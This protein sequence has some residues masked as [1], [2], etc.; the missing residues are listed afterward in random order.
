MKI[1]QMFTLAIGLAAMG[2]GAA[3]AGEIFDPP[4]LPTG[5]IQ[6]GPDEDATYDHNT[7]GPA[8]EPGFAFHGFSGILTYSSGY[9]PLPPA[10]L[11]VQAAFIQTYPGNGAQAGGAIDWTVSG[12]TVGKTYKLTFYDIALNTV[13]S[14]PFTVSALGGAPSL[15]TPASSWIL[16]SYTF[17][18]LAGV[19]DIDFLGTVGAPG[20]NQASALT[21]LSLSAVPEPSTLGLLLMGLFGIGF[22]ARGARG[23]DRAAAI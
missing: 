21:D 23:K 11:G 3:N 12:L 14:D 5:G 16:D 19:E 17:T 7:S 2:A 22:L 15:Y 1:C 4:T 9:L 8:V 18:A 10:G 13:S 20:S 6:Y